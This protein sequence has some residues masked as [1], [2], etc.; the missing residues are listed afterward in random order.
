MSVAYEFIRKS[1]LN[2]RR[3]VV[4][5]QEMRIIIVSVKTPVKEIS[6]QLKNEGNET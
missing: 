3:N 6:K 4:I 5:K 2:G 1:G